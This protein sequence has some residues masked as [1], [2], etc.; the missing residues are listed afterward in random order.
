MRSVARL[1]LGWGLCVAASAAELPVLAYHDLVRTPSGD[2]YAVTVAL[3]REQMEYLRDQGYQPIGLADYVAAAHGQVTLPAKP[4]MLTFDDGLASFAELALPILEQFGYPAV[5]SVTTGWL[6]NRDVPD[7]YRG[8]LLTPEALRKLS[9]S[10]RVEVL[11]HTDQ[12]HRGIVSDPQGS[13]GHA[14]VSRVYQPDSGYESDSA[15][16]ERVRADL[17]HSVSRLSEVT[18]RSPAGIAWPYGDS[19]AVLAEE[20]GRLG[21]AAQL[22]LDDQLADTRKYPAISRLLV[23][24]V[25]TLGGFENLLN[26]PRPDRPVRLLT[27]RLDEL[28]GRSRAQQEEWI[29]KLVGRAVLLRVDTVV[30]APLTADGRRAFFGNPALPV[31]ADVLHRVLFE[32]RRGA[33]IHRLYL[34]LPPTSL[35]EAAAH[36]LARRHPYDGI[37]L[38]GH[39]SAAQVASLLKEFGD[40]RP[41]LRCG[42][43]GA[44]EHVGCRS[45]RMVSMEAGTRSPARVKAGPDDAPIHYWV[46][47]TGTTTG[48]Q[49]LE[50][51]RALRVTGARHYGLENSALLDSPALLREV[52]IELARRGTAGSGG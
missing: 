39:E 10:A 2:D 28:A 24:K 32:L 30:V 44:T 13:L 23:Y 29:Q 42:T 18:G 46:R 6:D 43:S 36:E 8:R 9:R 20:A 22:R 37:V 47:V 19:N 41:G 12:L 14:A 17:R 31:D 25:N 1:L 15:Y 50:T 5:L 40:Y 7:N 33:A 26:T 16:R 34:E 27:V 52:A 4:V 51:L 21:M 11:S 49:V 35:P 45:F 38:A 3:F 48:S